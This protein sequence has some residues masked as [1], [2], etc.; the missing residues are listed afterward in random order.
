MKEKD[1]TNKRK[2][3]IWK[4]QS[5]RLRGSTSGNY[6]CIC[7]LAVKGKKVTSDDYISVDFVHACVKENRLL[8]MDKYRYEK[9][10]SILHY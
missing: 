4:F 1:V 5:Y 9:Y 3:E 8:D 2:M 6:H 10:L 7:R